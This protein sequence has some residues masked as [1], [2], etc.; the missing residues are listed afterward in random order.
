MKQLLEFTMHIAGKTVIS[1]IMSSWLLAFSLTAQEDVKKTIK[2]DLNKGRNKH[3]CMV[4][5]KNIKR[6]LSLNALRGLAKKE[7]AQGLLEE[8]KATRNTKLKNLG[9]TK[10]EFISLTHYINT[11]ADDKTCRYS[12][13]ETGLSHTIEYDRNTKKYFIVLEGDEV[14]IDSGMKKTVSKA[15]CYEKSGGLVVARAE[16]TIEMDRELGITKKFRGKPGLFKT[17]G[18]CQ[19]EE[20][21]VQYNTIY[22]QLYSPGSLVEIFRKDYNLSLYEKVL[23]AHN[24]AKGLD[25]LH[26]QGFVHRDLGVK[27]YLINIPKGK[28]GRR[29]IE[30]CIADFGRTQKASTVIP[31]PRL[32]GNT[33]YMAPEGHF[34]QRLTKNS[35]A[36][37]DIFAV[38]CVFYRLFYDKKPSWQYKNYVTKD[39]RPVSVKYQEHKS[40]VISATAKRREQ[41]R[42]Q[43]NRSAKAEF[44][45][46]ILR[47]L[48]TDP[49]KRVNAHTVYRTLARISEQV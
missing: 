13:K 44:E 42:K 1:L 16:Q 10:A 17:L 14:Y 2:K 19:H 31:D 34:F 12:K 43:K 9:I 39:P 5:R 46:I 29:Q 45:Y 26:K 32:Q 35:H 11:I 37:L 3:L 41:L 48:H 15:L 20:A 30:A 18:I 36:R 6:S 47:M 24:I 38:G 33:T 22:S 21:G 27:N 23:I 7:N 40:R 8:I 25:T 4:L 49:K 28:P